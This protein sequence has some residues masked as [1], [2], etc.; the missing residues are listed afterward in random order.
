M[1]FWKWQDTTDGEIAN[2][3]I[4]TQCYKP[5]YDCD[6][7][8]VPCFTGKFPAGVARFFIF[9]LQIKD[10]FAIMKVINSQKK[11][12]VSYCEAN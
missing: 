8:S 10:F 5:T 9:L 6:R 1:Y 12:G 7:G 4:N 3:K 2:F 11:K